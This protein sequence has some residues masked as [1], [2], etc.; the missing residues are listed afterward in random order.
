MKVHLPVPLTILVGREQEL[1]RLE[2]LIVRPEVRLLTLTGPGG[3]GKTRLALELAHRLQTAF[4]PVYFVPLAT[5]SDSHLVLSR[6]AQTLDIQES[7]E[8]SLL[9]RLKAGLDDQSTLL[10]LDNFEQLVGAGPVLSELLAGCPSLKIVA[11]SRVRLQ[12]YSEYE[13]PL[14]PLPLPVTAASASAMAH[15]PAVNLFI[16][17]VQALKPDFELSEANARSIQEIC[18]ALNGLPLAL[19]LAAA[20]LKMLQPSQLVG[21]LDEQLKL[22]VGGGR[23]LPPRQQTMRA[24]LD[25]S[26]NFL[27]ALEQLVFR[28]LSV[29]RGGWTLEAALQVCRGSETSMSETEVLEGLEAL[30][31]QSLITLSE[32]TGQAARYS[33]LEVIRQYA[34]ERLAEAAE[35]LAVHNQHCRWSWQLVETTTAQLWEGLDQINVLAR[36]ED[37][38]PN[39]RVALSWAMQNDP[40]TA[41]RLASE[42]TI[43]WDAH[44]YLTEGRYWLE[45]SLTHIEN[46][47]LPDK[48]RLLFA[49][50]WLDNRQNLF[51]L[52]SK[53]CGQSLAIYRELDDKVGILNTLLKLGWI[54][55]VQGDLNIAI[56]IV[57]EAV[58]LAEQA[59]NLYGQA[60][61]YSYLGLAALIEGDYPTAQDLC[62]KSVQICRRI[63]LQNQFLAW[64]LTGLGAV[65]LFRFESELAVDYFLES[66]S[67]LEK[68]GDKII[69]TYNLLGLAVVHIFQDQLEEAV[70][71][72]GFG[73]ALREQV[74]APLLP[75]FQPYYEQA[76][77]YLNLRLTSDSFDQL[78]QQ[79]YTASFSEILSLI[80]PL[81]VLPPVVV[82]PVPT[83][84][85]NLV[86]LT[87][88]ELEVVKLLAEGLTN[89]QIAQRL[90]LSPQTVASYLK[91]IF[92]KLNVK[93]RSAATRFALEN[94][95]V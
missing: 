72:F 26:Y 54:E 66:I 37:E 68:V 53:R 49:A 5:I 32:N 70:R 82:T 64:A 44:G 46:L 36:L 85:L 45:H 2:R 81:P 16:S 83:P 61:G 39:L 47:A 29:F 15:N 65:A 31:N 23:D 71:L 50:S 8:Q 17:R 84:A 41:S 80:K 63:G 3:V 69:M 87:T 92:S 77:K 57:K 78:W 10:V 58:A 9:E 60:A 86:S 59:A 19:E 7:A 30:L 35:T 21:R 11:T 90:T 93:S 42:L 18:T 13:F 55:L 56:P 91:T 34:W 24:S 95:L 67:G 40:L 33:M 89:A 88:R 48:A 43:F 79:G 6:I 27:S 28:R 74:G 1:T 4:Q 94:K 14:G 62:A 51:E 75:V 52:A 12:L 38:L 76:V 20:R 25:W 73:Q 22:L